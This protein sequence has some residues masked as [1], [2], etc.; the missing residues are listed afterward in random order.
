[1]L[2]FETGILDNSTD[3]PTNSI[4]ECPNRPAEKGQDENANKNPKMNDETPIGRKSEKS[5]TNA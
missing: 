1:M 4:R 3:W 2:E 5:P